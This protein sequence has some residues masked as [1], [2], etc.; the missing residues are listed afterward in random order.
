[1]VNHSLKNK[2]N[3]KKNPPT[4]LFHRLTFYLLTS[5]CHF[6]NSN[7]TPAENPL[8]TTSTVGSIK[9]P[10]AILRALLAYVYQE[11]KISGTGFCIFYSYVLISS[12]YTILN[13]YSTMFRVLIY[14]L[15]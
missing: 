14:G 11:C 6:L 5:S 2:N 10:P 4:K 8:T 13:K 15:R 7:I 3:K 1:M 12:P 9:I